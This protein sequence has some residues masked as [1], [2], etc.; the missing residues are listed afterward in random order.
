LMN[1]TITLAMIVKNE[2]GNLENCLI[3]VRGQVDEIVIVDTGST[4]GTMEIARKYTDKVYSFF[5]RED[6]S[7]ARNFAVEKASGDWIFYLDADEE[8][9]PGSGDLK[10]LA[11]RDL[12]PEA[13]LL[14]INNPIDG[15]TGEYNRFFVL[16]L[17]KNNGRY[18]FKGI[19]HEQVAVPENGVVEIAEGPVINHRKLPAGNRN[20]KRGRNL[21]LLI[22]ASSA[23]PRNR[24]LQYYLGVEWLMLGKPERALQFLQQA[25]RNLTDE[26]LLFRGPALRYLIICLNA[27]GR[28]DEAICL[29]LEADLKYPEYTDIY[30]LGGILFE[31]K[32]EYQLAIKWLSQAVKCGT[33]PPLYSHQNGSESFLAF[34]HLGYCHEMIGQT[35]AACGYYLQTLT[36]NP[37][38]IYPVY[39]LFL[40]ILAK[41]GPLRALEYFKEKGC[42]NNI[43]IAF[44]AAGLF[45]KSGY[46]DLARLCLEENGT[47]RNKD[48]KFRFYLGKYS[49][50]SGNPGQGIEFLKQISA[51]SEFFVRSQIYQAIALLLQERYSES[52][53][54]A[55]ALWKNRLARREARILLGL[56]RQM[57]KKGILDNCPARIGEDDMLGAVREILEECGRC[58]PDGRVSAGFDSIGL[59]EELESI[60][61][62]FSHKGWLTLYEYYRDKT[63]AWRDFVNYK[64]GLGG[65][66]S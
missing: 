42:L 51:E 3:S 2:A 66:R 54:K 43:E 45:F 44:T 26:N 37:K 39:N 64:F 65:G 55:L 50:F 16:R 21:S 30:Y 10:C 17:F 41:S 49:I 9:V 53:S 22:K 24:F 13:Y 6:F 5:W 18:R 25:Y 27:L 23:D 59:I 20:R 11:A 36:A 47:D 48:E 4:D 33:P 52:K 8:L 62:N 1:E 56:T 31:E 14:P 15:V 40:I 46:P 38:Y 58:L 61:K 34:Y 57:Q 32:Q 28:L 19:I 35:D 29:C 60:T 63:C 7:A 12:C